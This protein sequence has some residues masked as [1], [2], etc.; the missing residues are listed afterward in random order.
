MMQ[1]A[2]SPWFNPQ[3]INDMKILC[4]GEEWRGSNASG[5]FNAFS[6]KGF[7]IEIVNDLKFISLASVSVGAKIGNRLVRYFQVKDF[8]LQISRIANRLNPDLVLIYK[9]S[10][11]YPET[12][13]SIK[14]KGI[15]V[16][17]FFP[18]VSFT[19]HGKYIPFCIPLYD[20]IFTA[21]SFGAA[22]LERNFN[23][24]SQKV[25]FVPHGFDPLV[26]KRV[27]PSTDKSIACEASFIGNYSKDKFSKLS[28]LKELMPNLDLKIWGGIWIS[29]LDEPLKN[30]IQGIAVSGDSYALAINSS[31]VN[32]ALLSGLV[33]GASSGDQITSR[34]FDIP[35]AGGFMIHQRT[36]EV[37]LYYVEDQ[38]ICCFDSM[39][40]LADKI[41][42]YLGNEKE[43]LAIAERGYQRS[44]KE[45]SLDARCAQ[46][47]SILNEKGLIA[48][49]TSA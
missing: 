7:S 8:N 14:K 11:V 19:A 1:D 18:D 20:H 23:Y 39:E 45:H 33:K 16:I 12:I 30:A 24:T 43:R 27:N 41:K 42:F 31:K 40:E 6:R 25:S 13:L 5:L 47:I 9:G 29:Y 37:K 48:T 26:H 32:I 28:K 38:E 15:P 49:L 10:F 4:I 21:K 17:N 2:L 34:T 44:L 3:L 22:D 46:I 35:S 36:D